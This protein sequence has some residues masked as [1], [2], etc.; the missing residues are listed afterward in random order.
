MLSP[1]KLW[2]VRSTFHQGKAN[3]RAAL[4]ILQL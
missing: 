2:L 1:N 4:R 3:T